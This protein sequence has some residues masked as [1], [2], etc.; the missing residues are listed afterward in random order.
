[1]NPGL[2]PRVSQRIP[3]RFLGL[4]PDADP[5]RQPRLQ[6]GQEVQPTALGGLVARRHRKFLA[7]PG[8]EQHPGVGGDRLPFHEPLQ[9][10][11]PGRPVG[12]VAAGEQPIRVAHRLVRPEP[13]NRRNVGRVEQPGEQELILDVD[14]LERLDPSPPADQRRQR[15]VDQPTVDAG[16]PAHRFAHA[17]S[18]PFRAACPS[19]SRPGARPAPA[20]RSSW[21]ARGST[22][23]ERDRAADRPPKVDGSTRIS[24]ESVACF[25]EPCRSDLGGEDSIRAEVADRRAEFKRRKCGASLSEDGLAGEQVEAGVRPSSGEVAGDPQQGIR[26]S[27]ARFTAEDRKTRPRL[28]S[29][30]ESGAFPGDRNSRLECALGTQKRPDRRRPLGSFAPKPQGPPLAAIGFLCLSSCSPRHP[31]RL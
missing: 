8:G 20:R 15:P 30:R 7:K 5:E 3:D 11:R 14:Q 27:E 12:G 21:R 6:G 13:A 4:A 28:T 1:M 22:C 24:S 17:R 19:R 2:E 10:L 26:I 18:A 16:Q 31:S 25:C 23:R 29:P 9:A